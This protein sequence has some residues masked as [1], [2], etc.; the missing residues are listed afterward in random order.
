VGGLAPAFREHARGVSS[1]FL[2]SKL[3]VEFTRVTISIP[4]PQHG[5][6]AL[7]FRLL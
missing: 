2:L 5:G 1:L 7:K 3:F 4:N 6:G